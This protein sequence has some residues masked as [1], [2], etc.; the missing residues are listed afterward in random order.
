MSYSRQKHDTFEKS[1]IFAYLD[2]HDPFLSDDHS[3][4]SISTGVTAGVNVDVDNAHAVG[5]HIMDSSVSKN[6][7]QYSFCRKNQAINLN[8]QNHVCN[9]G[10]TIPVDFGLL[11]QRLITVGTCCD[12]L[13]ALF[14]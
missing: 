2:T 9:G 10:D 12:K 1:E 14:E 11:F 5:Q 3:L 13:S 6:V 7:S 8:S 4:R